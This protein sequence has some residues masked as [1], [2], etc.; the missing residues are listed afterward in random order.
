MRKFTAVYTIFT[1]LWCLGIYPEALGGLVAIYLCIMAIW[2]PI[3]VIGL[4]I[5]GARTQVVEK[6]VYR[7]PAVK[8]K[9]DPP[10]AERYAT[11]LAQHHQ[12]LAMIDKLPI[13]A[14]EKRD[15]KTA[16]ESEFLKTAAKIG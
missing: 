8:A 10:I 15:A 5:K 4:A 14:D 12:K 11:A 3:R 1:A 9:S 7:E 13:S 6:I 16:A 2:V